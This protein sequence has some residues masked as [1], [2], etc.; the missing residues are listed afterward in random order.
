MPGTAKAQRRPR[1][2]PCI[3]TQQEFHFLYQSMRGFP[4]LLLLL[5]VCPATHLTALAFQNWFQNWRTTGFAAISC[6]LPLPSLFMLSKYLGTPWNPF[7]K[8]R[9]KKTLDALTNGITVLVIYWVMDISYWHSCARV[10]R[11][12][13]RTNGESQK[14][15]FHLGNKPS[16][17]KFRQ[18]N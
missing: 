9:G 17:L 7:L 6:L 14:H 10:S 13:K 4:P 11:D 12:R 5:F 16:H 18:E 2:K 8:N 15:Q 3:I 1:E